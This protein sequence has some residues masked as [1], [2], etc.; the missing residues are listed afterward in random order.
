M[1]WLK[2]KVPSSSPTTSPKKKK[3]LAE[4]RN[5]NGYRI[6]K[7]VEATIKRGLR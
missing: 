5:K 4:S 3:N 1:E 7:L 6:F 2:V